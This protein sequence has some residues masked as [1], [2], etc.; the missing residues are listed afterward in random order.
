[1]TSDRESGKPA[2]I[3]HLDYHADPDVSYLSIL[4]SPN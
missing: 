4:A 3:Q 1:M 2:D